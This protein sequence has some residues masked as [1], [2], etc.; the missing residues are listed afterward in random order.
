MYDQWAQLICLFIPKSQTCCCCVRLR[1]GGFLIVSFY[2]LTACFN[3]TLVTWFLFEEIAREGSSD[4]NHHQE[5][6]YAFVSFAYLEDLL[7][8]WLAVLLFYGLRRSSLWALLVHQ[9]VRAAQ[10]GLF[11]ISFLMG[12]FIVKPYLVWG[13]IYSTILG[14]YLK[15]FQSIQTVILNFWWEKMCAFQIEI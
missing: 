6:S 10:C 3:F 15:R 2:L 13:F 5:L 1:T 7:D 9:W 11:F 14:E 4:A 12:I 8:V